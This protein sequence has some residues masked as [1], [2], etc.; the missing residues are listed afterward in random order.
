MLEVVEPRRRRMC[1]QVIR[2]GLVCQYFAMGED[3]LA[4]S[5]AEPF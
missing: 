3:N 1:L 5:N 2:R 4:I